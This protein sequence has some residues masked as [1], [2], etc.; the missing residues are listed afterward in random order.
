MLQKAP[1]RNIT[2]EYKSSLLF[3]VQV[4]PGDSWNPLCPCRLLSTE[5]ALTQ[6]NPTG[7]S[8]NPN[9]VTFMFNVNN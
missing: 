1:D 6:E 3:F 2:T 8:T 4:L 9:M 5:E 7:E